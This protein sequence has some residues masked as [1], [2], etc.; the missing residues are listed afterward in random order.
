MPKTTC[1]GCNKER[2]DVHSMGSDSNGAPD[3]PDLCFIC[4]KESK[5]GRVYNRDLKRYICYPLFII[6]P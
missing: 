2:N 3:S 5:R 6:K 1:D 4:R